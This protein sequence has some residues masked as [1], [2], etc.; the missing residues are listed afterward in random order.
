MSRYQTVILTAAPLS[1]LRA[2][3]TY[4]RDGLTFTV[5]DAG[6]ADAAETVVLLHGFP[7]DG[8]TWDAVVPALHDKG[9]RTLAPDLRGYSPGARPAGRAAY[10]IGAIA[11]DVVALL[12]AAGVAQAHVVGHDWGG[13]AAWAVAGLHP[14]RVRSLTVLSTP[15]PAALAWSFTHSS[16]ALKS[17][18]M[19]FFQLPRLPERLIPARMKGQLRATGLPPETVERYAARLADPSALAGALGWY[20][21]MPASRADHIGRIDVPTTYAW[22]RHDFALGRAAAEATSKYVRAAYLF[23][24]LEAGHWLPELN[25]DE[26]ASL[27][28][29]RV[30]STD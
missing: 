7:Q 16:Q 4:R 24:E 15:H 2:V 27:V 13:M 10:R 14:G 18:Y 26:V 17:W 20:R 1:R 6:P 29:D 28:L 30:S 9:L 3:E 22:G 12:D 21:G 23:V 25:P 11:G 8:G 19:A 5:R